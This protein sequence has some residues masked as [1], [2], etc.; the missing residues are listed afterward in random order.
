MSPDVLNVGLTA[1]NETLDAWALDRLFVYQ[2]A[3][4]VWVVLVSFPDLTTSFTLAK[5]NELALRKN[6]AVRIAPE[7]KVYAK[8]PE[9]M[10]QEV[11]SEAA[12][13]RSAIEGVGPS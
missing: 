12:A 10:L 1:L 7:L 8:I 3:G 13:S 5:G 11:A 4:G 9:P 2:F 6:L